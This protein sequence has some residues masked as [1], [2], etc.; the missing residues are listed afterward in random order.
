MS[1]HLEHMVYECL[2][3]CKYLIIK[4][5]SRLQ[6]SIKPNQ[7][8]RAIRTLARASLLQL[9]AEQF[10]IHHC[11]RDKSQRSS[12]S[13]SLKT[14]NALRRASGA[15][16]TVRPSGRRCRAPVTAAPALQPGRAFRSAATASGRRCHRLGEHR[17]H[18]M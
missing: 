12:A 4:T 11:F 5:C 6:G 2:P 18:N 14:S 15:R 3:C 7:T 16:S 1:V 17:P 8:D 13:R 9:E 10:S